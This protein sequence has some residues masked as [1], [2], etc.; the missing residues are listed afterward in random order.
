MDLVSGM[1][2]AGDEYEVERVLKRGSRL[3]DKLIQGYGREGAE[4]FVKVLM[5]TLRDGKERKARISGKKVRFR[6]VAGGIL[7]I[8]GS[9]V[10]F[11]TGEDVYSVVA[12]IRE[13]S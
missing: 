13:T 8:T 2:S 4:K 6:P 3:L 9:G 10:T 12:T 1:E 7:V 11:L 5:K